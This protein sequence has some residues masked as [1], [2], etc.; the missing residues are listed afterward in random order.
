M[1]IILWSIRAECLNTKTQKIKLNLCHQQDMTPNIFIFF[2]VSDALLSRKGCW[3]SN[4]LSKKLIVK[5]KATQSCRNHYN[6]DEVCFF[7]IDYI[8]ILFI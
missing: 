4:I 8:L 3:A 5:P 2:S 1:V 6:S 7:F